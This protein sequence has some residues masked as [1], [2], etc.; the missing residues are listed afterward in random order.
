MLGFILYGLP[1]TM[2]FEKFCQTIIDKRLLR[3]QQQQQQQA[4]MRK[5]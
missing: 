5:K 2:F 3:Q 4:F 1:S